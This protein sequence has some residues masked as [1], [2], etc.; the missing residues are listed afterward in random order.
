[1]KR[2]QRAYEKMFAA[3]GPQ[4]WWP[5]EGPFEVLVGAVLVQNTSWKNVE[6]AIAKI[7]GADK[8]HPVKLY[9][10]SI[11]ELTE[12]IRPAGYYNIKQKRLR[13]LLRL[14]V[15][16]HGGS[17]DR[18]FAQP[19]EL[20]R[21]QLLAVN[22]VGPET[23]DCILLYAGQMPSFVVDAYTNRILKRHG[24]L[25]GGETYAEVQKKFERALP[26]DVK[27]YNEYHA[28]LVE[29]GKDYCRP[30]NPKC[31]LCPLKSMLPKS[32]ICLR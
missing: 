5:G 22:G 4:G 29:V 1:M 26:R 12:L 25:K 15:K 11:A 16:E 3:L 23:A 30:R 32:G 19:M 24:W 21:E 9:E 17:L 20:L 13:N 31:D 18:M 8:M 14:V 6:R 7:R 28:L 10:Q 27:L 2:L